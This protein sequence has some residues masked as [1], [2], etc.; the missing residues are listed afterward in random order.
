MENKLI[1]NDEEDGNIT[2]RN[3]PLNQI[4]ELTSLPSAT[5]G[6]EAGNNA[7]QVIQTDF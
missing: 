2:F 1:L 6:N 5:D 4:M 7:A 3:V